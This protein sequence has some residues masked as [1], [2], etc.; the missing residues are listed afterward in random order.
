MS[1]A[2]RVYDVLL[3][4]VVALAAI[5][6]RQVRKRYTSRLPLTNAALRR[7]GVFPL[8]DHYYEPLFDP[9][10]L[11]RDDLPRDLP[12]IDLASDRQL[13]LLSEFNPADIPT[14]IPSR[15]TADG[16]FY[17]ANTAFETGDAEIW[18]HVIRHFKPERIVEIGSGYSTRAARLAIEAIKSADASYSCDHVCVEPY[19]MP[20]LERVGPRVIRQKVEDTDLALTD[21]LE[22]GDILF[23]DSSHMIRPEGDVL[24][25]F[26]QILPRLRPGVIVHVHDIFTPR[27]YP[28]AWREKPVFWDEQYLLEAF[29]THNNAWE[30]LLSLNQLHHDHFDSL[31]AVCPYVDEAS[32]PSS[33]YIRRR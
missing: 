23:I 7:A 10:G 27:D 18:M 28:I 9:S 33:F 8:L 13:Q 19:E 14:G 17:F 31:K 26:L 29:L 16:S 4:P 2:G 15:P 21:D 5:P 25:E 20:W 24:R 32:A 3:A 22:A 30:V 11:K 6:M 12:G 1:W